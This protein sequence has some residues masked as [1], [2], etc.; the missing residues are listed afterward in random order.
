MTNPEITLLRLL[1]QDMAKAQNPAL[2]DVLDLVKRLKDADEFDTARRVL[3]QVRPRMQAGLAAEQRVELAQAH[4]LCTYKDVNLPAEKRSSLALTILESIGL[5]SPDCRN[6]ETLGQGGAIYKYLWESSGQPEHLHT[7]LAFYLAGWQRDPEHDQG[8]CGVNAAY[9]LDLLAFRDRT[10]ARGNR[11]R[12]GQAKR[13]ALRARN[14]RRELL[15][16]LPGLLQA[17]GRNEDYW[18]VAT[19]AEVHFGLEQY[20]FAAGQLERAMGFKPADWMQKTTAF[21]F[22]N[23]ARVQQ[24]KPPKPDELNPQNWHA[25]WRVIA[26]LLG[27]DTLNVVLASRGKVGLALSGGGFRATLFHL[28]VLAR[29]A[30][31]NVLRSVETLSTV[32][33][34]S[35]GGALQDEL[36]SRRGPVAHRFRGHRKLRQGAPRPGRR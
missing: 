1:A 30:E 16:R 3:D 10:Q 36:E 28:G 18:F 6:K 21:Q 25:A 31:C 14:L 20:D 12:P 8:W 7:A 34:G 26:I 5:R 17:S 32:S 23:L 4:S 22:V 35:I 11:V 15:E 24:V 19:L 27:R 13:W 33:G 29:L 9:L 2:Q